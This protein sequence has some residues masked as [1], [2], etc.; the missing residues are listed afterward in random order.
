LYTLTWT[1][2]ERMISRRALRLSDLIREEVSKIIL[3]EVKDPRLGLI[4]VTRVKLSDDLKKAKIYWTVWG[5]EK[6]KEECSQGLESA[7][8][9]IKR[10]LGKR[11]RIKFMPDIDF[12]F[13]EGFE[14]E[15]RISD[16]IKKIKK[17]EGDE[18]AD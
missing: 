17:E 3:Y 15:Q 18:G 5:D 8:G 7:K 1:F 4:T 13:D 11:V 14:Y 12:A 16:L 6:S 2:G 10:E 9:F